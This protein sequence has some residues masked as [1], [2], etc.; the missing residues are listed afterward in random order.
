MIGDRLGKWVIFKELGRGGMG[1]VYLAQ[2]ELTGRQAALKV[3]APELAQE[4]G[5]LHRFQRE[6]ET[7]SKL[8]HPNIVRFFESGYE[9]GHYFYAMEYV[10]GANLDQI[11]EQHGRLPWKDVLTIALQV[12]PALRHVHDHG[13]IH[14]DIKPSNLI[15]NA[16]GQIKLTDFGIA[17]VFAATHLT[18]TGGIV[19]TAEFLSPEQAAGKTVGK[20]SDLYCLGCVLYMLLTGKPPFSGNTYVE[21]LHKHRYGQFDRPQK[22]VPDVPTEIDEVICQLLEKDP[23]KRPRDALVLYKQLD[24]ISKKLER[25]ASLTSS[26]NRDAP[27]QAENRTNKISMQDLPG[28]ATLMS[29]LVRAELH[30]QQRG[31]M[32]NRFINRPVVLVLVLLACIGIVAWKSWPLSQEELYQRGAN[33]MESESLYDMKQ[34]W[35]EYLE[36]LDRNHPGHPY[37][38]EVAAFRLKWETAQLPH[39][40]EAQRFFQQGELLQKQGNSAAAQK[41]WRN[42]IDAFSDIPSEKEW[43][44][45][46]RRALS[47]TEK[48]GA[49]K[50]RWKS[51]RAALARATELQQQGKTEEAARIL[52]GIEQLYGNDPAAVDLLLEVQRAKKKGNRS[53]S[54]K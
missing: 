46:A 43:V 6:I 54:R 35:T 18:A 7:L 34:G 28:P 39:S 30:E 53:P 52:R 2:E 15:C 29:R 33:L 45:Q 20:R 41:V 13:I 17:K 25:Q 3:L 12:V 31:G 23:D 47:D 19:G 5:F 50:D 38:E 22:F 16:Q 27:T 32:L 48:A 36:P 42:L 21:L 4:I 51:A 24:S 14:R 40:S 11:L 26:D 37:K 1:R 10:E 8:E 9:D 49:N 44:H